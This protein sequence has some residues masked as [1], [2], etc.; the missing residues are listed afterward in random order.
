MFYFLLLPELSIGTREGRD[1]IFPKT[2]IGQKGAKKVAIVH[3]Y[4][5]R[6]EAP[7]KISVGD[8]T[9]KNFSTDDLPDPSANLFK[10]EPGR[11]LKQKL[12]GVSKAHISTSFDVMTLCIK[13]TYDTTRCFAE[14]AV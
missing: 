14:C 11:C 7:V 6:D 3:G 13:R 8:Y 10:M 12:Y 4:V 2:I 1:D 9:K 5:H